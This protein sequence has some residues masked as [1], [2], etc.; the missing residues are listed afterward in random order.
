MIKIVHVEEVKRLQSLPEEVVVVVK[1]ITRA[2]DS[3]YGE[4]RDVDCDG[5]YKK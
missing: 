2:L 5:G 3:E 1:E 4:D